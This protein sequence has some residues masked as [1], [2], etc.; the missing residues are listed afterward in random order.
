MLHRHCIPQQNK[1]Q[2]LTIPN[3]HVIVL[4]KKGD[5]PL[6]KLDRLSSNHQSL[7][8]IVHES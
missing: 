4:H 2:G 6:P 3:H 1:T 8:D 5:R 7:K